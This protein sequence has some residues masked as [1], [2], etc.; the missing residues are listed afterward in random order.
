MFELYLPNRKNI[1]LQKLS[2]LS[3][4]FDYKNSFYIFSYNKLLSVNNLGK[5]ILEKHKL[6]K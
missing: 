5:H 2:K 3:L 1:D 4:E 6:K